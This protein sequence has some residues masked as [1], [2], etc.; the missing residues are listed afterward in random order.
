MYAPRA[1]AQTDL[2]L[3]DWLFAR[4][5]F[6]TLIS[7]GDDGQPAISHLP[8]LYQRDGQD[9][10]IEGHWARPNPQARA[11]GDAVIVLRGPHAYVSPSWYLDKEAAARVP[12]WNYAVAHLHGRC[13]Q[14]SDEDALGG[15]I[16]RMSA[17]F[18][19]RV[20]S[21]WQFEMERDSHR[22]QLRGLVGFRFVPNSIELTFKLSQ[23]HPAG[24][25]AA[26][27]DAL[28]RQASADSR[29]VATLMRDALRARDGAS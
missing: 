6:V 26:V 27:S 21:D 1:F 10:V 3:L 17:H 12:T 29:E 4:D 15:L 23:N 14:I 8:V 13:S 24:N 28:A 19:Q 16:A 7:Q 20:G 11:P 25:I 22:R 9:V 5:A 2:A 18:E